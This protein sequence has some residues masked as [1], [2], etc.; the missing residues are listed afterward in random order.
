MINNGKMRV[1]E[2]MYSGNEFFFYEI[3]RSSA[4]KDKKVNNEIQ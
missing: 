1:I 4:Y 2:R 3:K